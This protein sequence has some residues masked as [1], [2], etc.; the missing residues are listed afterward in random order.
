MRTIL[1][2][3]GT[4]LI[5]NAKREG[6]SANRAD[7][8]HVLATT[9][10]AKCCAETHGLARMGL[11]PEDRLVFVHS[12]TEEGERCAE[13]L[14]AYYGNRGRQARRAKVPGLTYDAKAVGRKG[15]RS[16]VSVLTELIRAERR[17]GRQVELNATGGFKAETAAATLVGLLLKAPVYYVYEKYEEAVKLPALPVSWDLSLFAL[18]AEFFEWIEEEP[19]PAGEVRERAKALPAELRE[20]LDDPEDGRRFLSY[21][22][23]AYLE[24]YRERVMQAPRV[25]VLLSRQARAAYEAAEPSTRQAFARCLEK[26]RV[27][28]LWA[29][30]SERDGPGRVMVY[31]RGNTNERVFLTEDA[32]GRVRAL[33]LARHSDG[34]YEKLRGKIRPEDYVQFEAWEG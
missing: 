31:P 9:D 28:E 12:D 16:M 3:V 11:K 7:L 10:A 4:S 18:H 23:R 29:N 1:V 13:A 5:S 33:E 21:A 2:T 32:E 34:S 20:L 22:G 27:R 14:C 8:L 24:A 26:L 25:E 19:R 30:Q 15:L 17:E 6:S